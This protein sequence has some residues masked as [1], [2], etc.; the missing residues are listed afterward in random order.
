MKQKRR[1][2]DDKGHLLALYDEETGELSIKAR[3]MKQPKVFTLNTT[4][5]Q[6]PPN[7]PSQR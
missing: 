6:K 5:T 7:T 4:K 3:N 1:L 2:E